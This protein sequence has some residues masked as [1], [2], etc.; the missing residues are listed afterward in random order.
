[1]NRV[2]PTFITAEV[3][4]V[5]LAPTLAPQQKTP[6][7]SKS[8]ASAPLPSI[9]EVLEKYV[10]SIGG[11]SALKKVYSRVSVGE[12]Q[13]ATTGV[14]LP[15]EIY[16][17]APNNWAEVLF[18]PAVRGQTGRGYDGTEGW[19]SNMMETGLRIVTGEE[20]ATMKR[21]FDFYW[22][23][24]LKQLYKGLAV[25]GR[26]NIE[27]REVIAVDA[28]PESGTLE[29]MYFQQY[30][31]DYREVDGLKLPFTIWSEGTVTIITKLDK[32]TQNIAID[33]SRFKRPT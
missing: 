11:E 3:L 16:A 5:I 4:V 19:S 2:I 18:N 6:D 27:G 30:L 28:L 24:R 10:Q 22:P 17:K 12:W 33:D 25:T 31:K 8:S 13:N 32:V 21:E 29:K 9:D 23:I 15:L 20:L 7:I 1:M 14:K 26:E